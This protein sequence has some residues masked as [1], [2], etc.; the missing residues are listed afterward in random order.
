MT[1]ITRGLRS[2]LS[3]PKIYDL[4]SDLAG[5]KRARTEFIQHYLRPRSGNAVL[6]IGCGTGVMFQAMPVD[7]DYTGLDLS[8]AYIEKA[9]RSF[10]DRARFICGSVAEAPL[11]PSN[12]FDL[13][14]AFGVLHH[15]DDVQAD[16]LLSLAFEVLKPNGRLVTC[17]PVLGTEGEGTISRWI[18]R[19]DR[20]RNVRTEAK[21]LALAKRRF[22]CVTPSVRSNFVRL[23]YIHLFLECEKKNRVASQ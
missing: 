14:M 11:L 17:D 10:G 18:M 7:V 3:S 4:W 9:R 15:L 20:G 19:Q 21:Y 12:G 1:Q 13:A 5:A 22:P 16:Q 6:D 2:I 8:E 23:P